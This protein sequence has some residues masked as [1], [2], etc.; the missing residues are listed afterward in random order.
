MLIFLLFF[1]PW[2]L[3]LGVGDS[4]L[5]DVHAHYGILSCFSGRI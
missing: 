3:V 5:E 1:V 2:A 4:L